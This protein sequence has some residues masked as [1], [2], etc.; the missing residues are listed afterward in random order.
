[1]L[2][3]MLR[4]LERTVIWHHK[5]QKN[6]FLSDTSLRDGEQMPGIRLTPDEKVAVARALAEAGIHSILAGHHGAHQGIRRPTIFRPAVSTH[7]AVGLSFGSA[8]SA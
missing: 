1:M 5:R 6:V 7:G 8:L 3:A 4:Q 2:S